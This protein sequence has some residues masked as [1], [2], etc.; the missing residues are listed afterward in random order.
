MSTDAG[1]PGPP[2]EIER[3]KEASQYLRGTL[4]QSLADPL[5]G[6]LAAAD[7][8]LIK[9]HGTYQQD[10]RDARERRQQRKLEPLHSF[11]V[12]IRVPGGVLRPEQWLQLDDLATRYG[13]E[14]LR[15]TTRQA[16]Q[17]H[18]VL[19]RDLQALIR[20][21]SQLGLDTLA[22]C[23]D[24]NR[25]VICA[26]NPEA[27]ELHAEVYATAAAISRELTPHT[28]AYREIWLDGQRAHV[29]GGDEEPLYGRTYLPRKFKIALAIPPDNDVDVFA[30]DLGF[31]ALRGADGALGG[32][33]VAV[34]GGMGQTHGV[35]ATYPQLGRVLGACRV[36]EAVEVATAVVLLQRDL[37]DRSDRRQARLK[38]TLDRL[39]VAAFIA[40]L[41]RRRGR[42]LDPAQPYHFNR[43]GDRY[44]WQPAGRGRWNLGLYVPGGRVRDV[45]NSPWRTGLR[46]LVSAHRG[47][48]R[49]TPN[50]NLMLSGVTTAA[51]RPLQALLD[52]H[53]LSP[54]L[55]SPV[56]QLALACVA[57]P[58]CPLAMAEAER[59]LPALLDRF[60]ALL[61]QEGLAD[62]PITVRVTGCPN[63]CA[64]PYLAEVALVGKGPGYYNLYL[65]GSPGGERLNQLYRENI[66]E[67]AILAA[68]VPLLR[69]YAQARQA[70]EAFGDFVV[71]M[72]H[73]AAVHD[74][75]QFHC[76]VPA[77][78]AD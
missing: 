51:R 72:G 77:P 53:Q 8:A 69:Q 10:D 59:Y 29:D 1:V 56:R 61:R 33:N 49:L 32:Y 67:A 47:D 22:A 31:I 75:R 17:L 6:G 68:L 13:C 41:G 14:S 4:L 28:G 23:G 63:G 35:P 24:V 54:A 60:D 16:V 18:G 70:G 15:L 73:V 19:K 3:L 50:Q 26:A 43:N 58:T 57:L 71:R 74:G 64:R 37:G 65:G 66:D 40:A 27:S 76:P 78:T 25:N 38:Y 62:Q 46:A 48:L 11:M 30:H 9:F 55:H 12:R 52:R 34:G 5:T 42:L 21:V 20:D 39:G 44:G 45:P 7:Q 2:S 36:D